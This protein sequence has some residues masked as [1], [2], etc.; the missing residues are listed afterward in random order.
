MSIVTIVIDQPLMKSVLRLISNH[1]LKLFSGLLIGA[2]V[3]GCS[4]VELSPGGEK[5]QQ[6]SRQQALGCESVGNATANSLNN[7]LF[8]ER[9]REKLQ[10]ELLVLARN[11]A[12]KLGGN[13]VVPDGEIIDGTQRF[14]VYRCSN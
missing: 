8:I 3:S 6:I 2:V 13:A 1:A 14:K 4:W 12:V 7:V 9:N 5:V 10:Q 11:E